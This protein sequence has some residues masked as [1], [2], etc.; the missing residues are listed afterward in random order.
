MNLR[1]LACFVV[2]F[3]ANV[4]QAQANNGEAPVKVSVCQLK[5]DPA[6]YEHKLIEVT[7]FVT[8]P[9][10]ED[11]NVFDPA[12]AEERDV[13]LEYGGEKI[14]NVATRIDEDARLKQF[15]ELIYHRHGNRVVHAT[16]VGRFFA[17]KPVKTRSGV[18][19]KGR[20]ILAIQQIASVDP[21]NSKV[22]DYLGEP[23]E[24]ELLKI[25]CGFGELTE[26]FTN[27]AL[28]RAQQKADSGE[29]DWAFTD[30]ARVATSGL[31]KLLSIDEQTIKL[32]LTG[33]AQ[34]RLIYQWQPR[35]G[36]DNYLVVVSQP[37]IV[38]FYAKNSDRV[39]WILIA[40]FASSCNNDKPVRRIN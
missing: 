37:Y 36:G 2:L 28:I 39:A 3:S 30:P 6:A 14:E 26:G 13:Q 4:A 38:S 11:F 24:P 7:G 8:Q 23:D 40:A 17:A 16:I 1:F 12:C 35:T 31:A 10:R 19:R 5:S 9:G 29:N 32:R 25:G 27:A 21:H 33:R 20:S 34:G 18:V 22:L 15:S